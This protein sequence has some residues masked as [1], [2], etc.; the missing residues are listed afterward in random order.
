MAL[1]HPLY[2]YYEGL[3]GTYLVFEPLRGSELATRT[4]L[5]KS[6]LMISI[7]QRDG[8]MW[9]LYYS[10]NDPFCFSTVTGIDTNVR[11]HLLRAKDM[12]WRSARV[13][14]KTGLAAVLPPDLAGYVMQAF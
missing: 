4:H 2:R 6:Q 5:S 8:G 9:M 11:S 14:M 12:Y 10:D 1:R 13:G 3:V 7:T